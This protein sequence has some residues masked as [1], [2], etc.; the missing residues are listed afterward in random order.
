MTGVLAAIRKILR[1]GGMLAVIEFFKIS[2][3]SGP[4]IELRLSQ[5]ELQDIVLS[6][7]YNWRKNCIVGPYNYLSVFNTHF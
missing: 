7:G 4:P 2:G 3:Q 5:A 1:P 6:C